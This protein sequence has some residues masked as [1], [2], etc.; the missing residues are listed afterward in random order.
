MKCSLT[1]RSAKDYWRSM[2]EWVPRFLLTDH[3]ITHPYFMFY[4]TPTRTM[5][6]TM[7]VFLLGDFASAFRFWHYFYG[8]SAFLLIPIFTGYVRPASYNFS[9]PGHSHHSLLIRPIIDTPRDKTYNRFCHPEWL[10]F[11]CQH[12][13]GPSV[14]KARERSTLSDKSREGLGRQS[15]C[16]TDSIKGV[17]RCDLLPVCLPFCKLF[18]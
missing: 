4:I 5:T 2:E 10:G 1:P 17:L 3:V 14:V 6:R 9:S 11:R 8:S 7:S 15:V 12:R 18:L 16:H 13:S